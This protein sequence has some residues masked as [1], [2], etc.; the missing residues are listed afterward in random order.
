MSKAISTSLTLL[1]SLS[2]PCYGFRTLS[3]VATEA[4]SARSGISS[5]VNFHSFAST[6][7]R[8]RALPS[9]MA[10]GGDGTAVN[11]GGLFLFDFDGGKSL[12]ISE[13]TPNIDA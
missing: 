8:F 10:N 4:G 11:D 1:A 2:R 5:Y 7:R 12:H 13:L 3:S 6:T 9:K